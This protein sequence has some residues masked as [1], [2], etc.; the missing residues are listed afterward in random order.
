MVKSNSLAALPEAQAL[1]S[2]ISVPGD[3]V[4]AA[5]LASESRRQSYGIQTYMLAKH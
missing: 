5:L 2:G 4:P 1:V 3:P